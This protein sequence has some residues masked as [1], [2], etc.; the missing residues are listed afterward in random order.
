MDH[1]LIPT[2]ILHEAVPKGNDTD[3]IHLNE[4]SIDDHAIICPNSYLRIRLHL[5]GTFYYFSTQIPTPDKI[6]DPDSQVVVIKPEGASWNPQCNFYQLN[7]EAHTNYYGNL[8]QPHHRTPHLIED[9]DI[10]LDSM[11]TMEAKGQLS[12]RLLHRQVRPD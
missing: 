5:H 7:E 9:T 12:V 3:M 8:S 6:L 11:R 2:F 1:N 4:P 10:H